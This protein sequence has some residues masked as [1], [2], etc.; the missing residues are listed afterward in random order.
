M[1]SDVCFAAS[2]HLNHQQPQ[3]LH[4]GKRGVRCALAPDR[5]NVSQT[6]LH[7]KKTNATHRILPENLPKSERPPLPPTHKSI[8]WIGFLFEQ[9]LG[10]DTV[11]YEK[12]E[13]YG[14][15]YTSSFFLGNYAYLSDYHAVLNAFRDVDVFRSDGAFDT[16]KDLFG[17]DNMIVNDFEAHTRSRNAVAP[18]FSPT[19]FPYYF[20]IIQ[21]RVRNTWEGVLAKVA[22]DGEVKFAEVFREHYL[23][24]AI[25]LTTGVD[26]TSDDAPK[27]IDK[28]SRMQLAFFTPPFGPLWGIGTRARDEIM[29]ILADVVRRDLKERAETI[30]KLREYGDDIMKLGVKDIA[31][32]EV[33]VLLVLIATSSLSTEPGA[34]IDE[35]VVA[36]L[37]RPMLLLWTAGYQTSAATSMCTSFEMGLDDSIYAGLVA[38]QDEI[39]AKADGDATVTYEQTVSEMPLLDSFIMEMLRLHPAAPAISRKIAK[40]VEVLGRFLPKDSKVFC[41]IEAAHRNANI[42]PDPHKIV[43]NRF[44]KREGQP[45]PPPLLSFGAPGS[46]HYCIGALLAKVLMKTTFATL[47]REYTYKLKP[48]QTTKYSVVPE[49]VP[50]SEVVVNSFQRRE[51]A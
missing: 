11:S 36:S 32:G 44:L 26:T 10:I 21:R 42:Y 2:V 12:S 29:D 16:F 8:P 50:K 22:R 33:D 49:P 34:P 14:P 25:E 15:I 45:K 3:S 13:K 46:P 9:L 20:N 7:D 41:D 48:G 37:C 35:E 40:D 31:K 24:I 27:I 23:S 17:E 6:S 47:L 39:V 19:L 43:M 1:T 4:P 5:T 38:E 28:F 18:A 30:N 51:K